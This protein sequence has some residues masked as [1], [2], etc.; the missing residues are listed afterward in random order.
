[1]SVLSESFQLGKLYHDIIQVSQI[2]Y[3]PTTCYPW[4]NIYTIL[5]QIS[6]S[7]ARTVMARVCDCLLVDWNEKRFYDSV[8]LQ[9]LVVLAFFLGV[10]ISVMDVSCNFSYYIQLD[11]NTFSSSTLYEGLA[12][13][14]GIRPCLPLFGTGISGLN[15]AV[16]LHPHALDLSLEFTSFSTCLIPS[17]TLQLCSHV[18]AE[19]YVLPSS[20]QTIL[21]KS[22]FVSRS[23]HYV[24]PNV[25][26]DMSGLD[27]YLQVIYNVPTP[28]D[29]TP[30]GRISPMVYN[31]VDKIIVSKLFRTSLGKVFLK[32]GYAVYMFEQ[33]R[34]ASRKA[35]KS[36]DVRTNM[37]DPN[38][39]TSA[40]VTSD[41]R[42]KLVE[43]FKTIPPKQREDIA[44]KTT[45]NAPRPIFTKT[46]FQKVQASKHI[47]LDALNAVPWHELLDYS[48]N[49][50]S[51]GNFTDLVYLDAITNL[52]TPNV[53]AHNSDLELVMSY[54]V[55]GS[56]IS[57]T[58]VDLVSRSTAKP[59]LAFP[60]NSYSDTP[61]NFSEYVK[62]LK[63]SPG[64][65]LSISSSSYF[66]HESHNMFPLSLSGSYYPDP[67]NSPLMYSD[68]FL[69]DCEFKAIL[70]HGI[71][72]SNVKPCY[73]RLFLYVRN[74]GNSDLAISSQYLDVKLLFYISFDG[75]KLLVMILWPSKIATTLRP[76]WIFSISKGMDL[77]NL[78]MLEFNGAI[79]SLC[80][81]AL[82]WTC[83]IRSLLFRDIEVYETVT[84]NNFRRLGSLILHSGYN[85]HEALRKS[86][87]AP[88]IMS[89][90]LFS[91][92]PNLW[93]MGFPSVFQRVWPEGI[94]CYGT[95]GREVNSFVEGLPDSYC[96][97]DPYER[98]EVT[99]KVLALAGRMQRSYSVVT[100]CNKT[101][102]DASKKY[103][104]KDVTSKVS[105]DYLALGSKICSLCDYEDIP[106]LEFTYGHI[107]DNDD[108]PIPKLL[109][110][111]TST[112]SELRCGL[113]HRIVGFVTRCGTSYHTSCF[114][115]GLDFESIE[116]L[117][118]HKCISDWYNRFISRTRSS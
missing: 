91:I 102:I 85:L 11:D 17:I 8:T 93:V 16:Y 113:K 71:Y 79:E 62:A 48:K 64:R 29:Y 108:D 33:V 114:Y 98:I 101:I 90:D 67:V 27:P 23:I 94:L 56:Q 22:V 58:A 25:D 21:C 115:Y 95:D 99:N 83:E 117:Y 78:V 46:W 107:D 44:K 39:N 31:R 74:G 96:Q 100:K 13:N 43:F 89:V 110:L 76:W 24:N 2:S 68:K 26:I 30:I 52:C 57:P 77:A 4:M 86:E 103:I 118:P 35:P 36:V 38:G 116:R 92:I 10:D 50:F 1:M 53:L 5:Q 111:A 60:V 49:V 40:V 105:S 45:L 28:Y 61:H 81:D 19:S 73:W 75:T 14:K 6:T 20:Y 42:T 9:E 12:H 65:L 7:F 82:S 70:P 3:P 32:H 18:M 15:Q 41:M 84:D 80:A 34:N 54:D 87:I 63:I 51:D 55:S 104:W 112:C 72:Q 47:I 66:P 88:L 106:T 69:S 97:I 109:N 59:A 37:D